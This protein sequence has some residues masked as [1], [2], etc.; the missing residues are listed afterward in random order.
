MVRP[1]EISISWG[2]FY[3]AAHLKAEP[4][5]WLEIAILVNARPVTFTVLLARNRNYRKVFTDQRTH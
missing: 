2:K 1:C 5:A 3:V 4:Y